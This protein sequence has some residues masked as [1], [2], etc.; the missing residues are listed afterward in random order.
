MVARGDQSWQSQTPRGVC[1]RERLGNA[2]ALAAV[3]CSAHSHWHVNREPKV[4]QV[5]FLC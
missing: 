1:P 4:R 5:M 3:L 2:E